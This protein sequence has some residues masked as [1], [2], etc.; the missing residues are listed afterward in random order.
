MRTM[1]RAAAR[2]A[3]DPVSAGRW[4]RWF[5]WR[6]VWLAGERRLAFREWVEWRR[7]GQFSAYGMTD[8]GTVEY[9]S[10]AWNVGDER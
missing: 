9:R 3:A 4:E 2:G 8:R 5:A 10:P 1:H 6:P 7:V